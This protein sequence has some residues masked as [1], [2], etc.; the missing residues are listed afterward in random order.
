MRNWQ[1]ILN[2]LDFAF[3]PIVNIHSGSIY[4]FEALLR[5]CEQA[6]FTDIDH[7]FSEAHRCGQLSPIDKILREKALQKFSAAGW[8]NKAMLFYNLDNRL[9]ESEGFDSSSIQASV[10]LFGMGNHLCLEI[11]EKQELKFDGQSM[12]TVRQLRRQGLRIAIDDYGTG[13]SGLQLLYYTDPDFIKIDRF[14]IQD[15]ATDIKKKLFVSSLVNNAHMMGSIVLAEGVETQRE[16]LECLEI[17][18][19]LIQGYFVQKPT[20]CMTELQA[21]YPHVSGLDRRKRNERLSDRTL[22]LSGMEYTPPVSIGT[23]LFDIFTLFQSGGANFIPIVNHI[24]EPIGIVRE[25]SFKSFAYS[26]F[27]RELLQNRASRNKLADF[28]DSLP[29]IDIHSTAEHILEVFNLNK[30]VEAILITDQ[31]RYVG[32]LSASSLLSVLHE[33]N[34]AIARDQNPLTRLPG[35]NVI[36]EFVSEALEGCDECYTVVYFDFDKFKPYNDR[37]GFRQGDRVILRFAEILREFGQATLT[38]HIGGD[39]FFLGYRRCDHS[40][41]QHHTQ[42]CLERFQLDIEHFYDSEDIVNGFIR[43]KDR[44]GCPMDFPIMT[45]SAVIIE[46]PCGRIRHSH[47]YLSKVLANGKKRAKESPVHL[48]FEVLESLALMEMT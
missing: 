39:D 43:S 28:I 46:M 32:H 29:T 1:Y 45:I 9:L 8:H 5:G 26:R 24:N 7:F 48:H 22:I 25:A 41:V 18:C 23:N 37:Y 21:V 47:D 13:F 44:N 16:Y 27:G 33:K 14:F 4:G 34:L 15:I 12:E 6:D 38:A 30:G 20:T 19:D 11:S 42:E 3:Q 10:E 36:F 2:Q 40:R 17:G 35:N 31:M